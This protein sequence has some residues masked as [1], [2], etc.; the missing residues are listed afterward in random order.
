MEEVNCYQGMNPTVKVNAATTKA[1][2]DPIE[3]YGA[4]VTLQSCPKLWQEGQAV[5]LLLLPSQWI[6]AT[7]WARWLLSAKAHAWREIQLDMVRH[8]NSLQL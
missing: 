6:Q 2:A 4:G 7:T 3:S 1:S 5:M 8:P